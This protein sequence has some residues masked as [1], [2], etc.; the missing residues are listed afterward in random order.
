LSSTI[1]E[2][3]HW[4]QRQHDDAS[5]WLLLWQAPVESHVALPAWLG[6][7]VHVNLFFLQWSNKQTAWRCVLF[8][9]YCQ[10]DATS[11]GQFFMGNDWDTL[12]ASLRPSPN[13]THTAACKILAG[14]GPKPKKMVD[15][16][17]LLCNS[18]GRL[19]LSCFSTFAPVA[20][21]KNEGVAGNSIK[22]L[23]DPIYSQHSWFHSVSTKSMQK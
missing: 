16:P 7:E 13:V 17:N 12:V 5:A 20:S 18:F 2:N 15:G 6:Q 10:C 22:F 23:L 9:H 21:A 3:C 1:K 4:R 8:W 19:L 14:M 11:H